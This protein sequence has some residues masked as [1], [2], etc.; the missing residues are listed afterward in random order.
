MKHWAVSTFIINPS[1]PNT[2]TTH[3]KSN[4]TLV[5]KDN[6]S[7]GKNNVTAAMPNRLHA[8]LIFA[9]GEFYI[10]KVPAS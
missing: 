6:F 4:Q 10:A 3:D 8:K 2:Y 7:I 5:Y 1:E 9:A